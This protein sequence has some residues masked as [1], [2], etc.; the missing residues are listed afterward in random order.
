MN[1][2]KI[3]TG[4]I[5]NIKI[6]TDAVDAV[7]VGTE[8]VWPNSTPVT[9]YKLQAT[10]SDSSTYDLECDSSTTLTQSEVS[11]G[12]TTSAITSAV[13]GDCVTEIGLWA[14]N[15]GYSLSSV[16]LPS[17]L[18]SIVKSAFNACS[19]LLSIDIPS[20]VTS[21]G[22][23]AFNSCSSLS[24][25]T[26]NST[27]PP[28]LGNSA[29][30]STNNCPIYV[31]CGTAD[32]YKAASG[33][34]AYANRIQENP[35]ACY[36]A[37]LYYTGGT[38]DTVVCDSSTTLSYDDVKQR[39]MAYSAMTS[40]E[41]GDCVTSIDYTAFQDCEML[42]SVSISNTVTSIVG[43]SFN[44]CFA[45][46]NVVIPDSVTAIGASSFAYCSGAT[47]I[48]LGNGVQTIGNSAFSNCRSL[49]SVTIPSSITSIGNMAFE[50]CSSLQSITIEATTP[51]T[52][53]NYVFDYTNDCPIYV[54]A[55]SVN[56]YKTALPDD[57]SRIQAIP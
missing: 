21:I 33:W 9:S 7:Y 12:G 10:Y 18:T 24:S 32:T 20:G 51:P 27:T 45:L 43:A 30:S 16:T 14:F 3:G 17:G 50:I 31:P 39:S 46:D 47:S 2:I 15:R 28:T 13:I 41:I 8:K 11:N 40:A 56:A 6:G 52:F 34:S 26:I 42:S 4:T 25:I 48:S 35:N 23:Y 19:S 57:V 54:P 29:F 49:T 22:E 38:T 53:G 36:K 37:K 5:F 1:D 55:S 44:N